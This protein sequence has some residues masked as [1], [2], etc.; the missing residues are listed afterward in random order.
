MILNNLELSIHEA[1]KNVFLS[2]KHNKPWIKKAHSTFLE[3]HPFEGY[4]VYFEI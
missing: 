1:E 2:Y 3:S 4:E